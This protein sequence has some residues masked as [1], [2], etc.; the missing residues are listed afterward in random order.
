[1]NVHDFAEDTHTAFL[2]YLKG[3]YWGAAAPPDIEDEEK[4]GAWED[5][6]Y[7]ISEDGFDKCVWE[8]DNM[9]EI[10]QLITKFETRTYTK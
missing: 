6:I 2:V 7:H 10:V 8:I 3:S 5:T 9:A 1:M 4:T